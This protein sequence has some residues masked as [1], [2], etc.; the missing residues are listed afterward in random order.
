MRSKLCCLA[1]VTAVIALALPAVAGAD[2]TLGT[3]TKPTGSA[4]EACGTGVMA[5]QFQSEPSTSYAVPA[6]GG[7]ITQWQTNTAGDTAGAPLE[8]VVLSATG[9]GSYT[10]VAVD[11]QSVPNPLPSGGIATFTPPTPLAVA[12]GDV[13]GLYDLGSTQNCGWINGS[14]PADDLLGAF[15]SASAP[16]PGQTAT[17]SASVANALIDVAATFAPSNQDAG[18]TTSAG[19]ANAAAGRSALLSSTVSNGG[20]GTGPITFVDTVPAGLAIDSAAAGDGTCSTS[21]QTVTCTINGLSAGQSVPVDVVVTP[22]AARTYGNSVSVA[23]A[24][25]TTD[26]NTSNNTASA[27]LTVGPAVSAVS[28]VKCVVPKLKGT[29]SGVA[30]TVLK[31][32]GCKVK[33]SHAHSS[34][35]HKGLV[36]KTKPGAGTYANLETVTLI[37]SSGPKKNRK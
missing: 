13:L 8:L 35:V 2:V 16:V 27:T 32:L 19:P 33:L 4:L 14:I 29:P 18:V 10:I 24:A 26:P 15:L 3:T 1:G 34:A 6:P 36:I 30:R 21:G 31:E 22:S 12:A 23:V 17:P 7:E 5:A 9:E 20:P 25:G 37:V 28:P 11:A